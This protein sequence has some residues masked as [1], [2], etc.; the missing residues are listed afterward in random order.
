MKFDT[1]QEVLQ[2]GNLGWGYTLNVQKF[3]WIFL[4]GSKHLD[5]Y[6]LGQ[7]KS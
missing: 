7:S 5:W 4:Y 2:T 1:L 6:H 3:Q